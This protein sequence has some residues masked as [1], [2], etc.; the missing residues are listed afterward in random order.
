MIC[1]VT[2]PEGGRT[3]RILQERDVRY[4]VLYEDMPDR[5][6]NDFWRLFQSRPDL[7]WKVLENWDVLIVEPRG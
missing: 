5:P 7:Y 1:V 3:E 6:T 4:V 2:H